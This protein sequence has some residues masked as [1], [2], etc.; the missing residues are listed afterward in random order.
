ME[1]MIEGEDK[2]SAGLPC[3][4]MQQDLLITADRSADGS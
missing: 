2:S 3:E 1:T 4:W